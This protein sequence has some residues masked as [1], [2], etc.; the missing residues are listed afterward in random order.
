MRVEGKIVGLELFGGLGVGGIVQQD[1][2]ED[3]LFGVDIRGQPGYP[4]EIGDGGHI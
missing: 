2:A 1:R 3:G 4:G